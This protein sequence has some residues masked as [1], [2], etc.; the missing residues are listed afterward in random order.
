[1]RL[2]IV[3]PTYNEIEN[4]SALIPAVFAV[5][6]ADNADILVVDDN[7]PDGTAQ[8]VEKSG[9]SYGERLHL[10]RREGKQGLGTAYLAGFAWGIERGYDVFLEM[11]ADFSHKPEFIPKM[12]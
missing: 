12:L 10:L 11:D 6:P 8:A 4:I 5:L 3:I 1:M 7:S 2:L 9:L